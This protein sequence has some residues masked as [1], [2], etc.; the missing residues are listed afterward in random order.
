VPPGEQS[1]LRLGHRP[2]ESPAGSAGAVAVCTLGSTDL[3]PVLS[4]VAGVGIAGG[5]R[6]ANL[7][8]E[9]IVRA[10]LG[11]PWLRHLVLC[12]RDSPLF[13]QGQS[14][15]ALVRHGLDPADRRIVGAR[16]HLPYLRGTDPADVD[17]FRA[18]IALTDLRGVVDP[19]TVRHEVAA[20]AADVTTAPDLGRPDPPAPA[21]RDLPAV[22]RREPIAAAGEGFFV[23]SV[24][25]SRHRVVVEH[26]H[27]DLRP[28]HRVCGVR[29]ESLLLG[30][31]GAGLVRAAGHAG[32]LGAELA[33]A[34]TALRLGLEYEQD[35]PLRPAGSGGRK[36]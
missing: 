18:Q 36:S 31:L 27:P 21:F 29:A 19:E 15:V 17:A 14:L 2:A 5:L 33:K 3:V 11:R 28:G 26:Y 9:Q 8:I 24:D 30:L 35:R 10:V 32:Y 23:I 20:L 34:E 12:G 25:R 6:T 1:A 16:G 7:G 22:G 13:Q 4:G